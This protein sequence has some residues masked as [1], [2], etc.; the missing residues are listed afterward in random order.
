VPGSLAKEKE[1]CRLGE[2]LDAREDTPASGVVP[3]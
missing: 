2:P 3:A 1:Q